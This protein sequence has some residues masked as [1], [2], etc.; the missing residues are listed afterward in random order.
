LPTVLTE[1]ELLLGE[2]IRA[3]RWDIL[4]KFETGV[5]GVEVQPDDTGVSL[6][7]RYG[8]VFVVQATFEGD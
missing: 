6:I 5:G 8:Q 1:E 4:S 7:Q 3:W 2:K